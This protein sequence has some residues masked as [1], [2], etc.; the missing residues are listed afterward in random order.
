MFA[1]EDS[2][3]D[4]ATAARVADRLITDGRVDLITCSGGVDLVNAVADRAEVLGCPCLSSFHQWRP[5]VFDRGRRNETEFKWTYA[6]AVGLEDI[7]ANYLAVWYQVATNKKVG[8]VLMDDA[9][10]RLWADSTTG[11]RPAA[12]ARGYECVFP[13]LVSGA[14]ATT[15][16]ASP[17]S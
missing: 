17:S 7:V 5:F 1:V 13:G 2:R 3:S 6:H 15:Q 4:S 11:L 10:G 12:A 9:N 8:L 14:V 16:R